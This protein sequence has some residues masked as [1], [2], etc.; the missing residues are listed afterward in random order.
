MRY[1]GSRQHVLATMHEGRHGS[2]APG[3]CER[4]DRSGMSPS[5]RPRSRTYLPYGVAD[6]CEHRPH[7]AE[8]CEQFTFAMN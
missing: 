8:L 5:L 2:D 3:R 6:I 7:D 4:G 1:F